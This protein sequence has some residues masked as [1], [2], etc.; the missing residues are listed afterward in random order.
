MANFEKM[1]LKLTPTSEFLTRSPDE[2]VV[3][4]RPTFNHR[5]WRVTE[6][7]STKVD[8]RPGPAWEPRRLVFADAYGPLGQLLDRVR[9]IVFEMNGLSSEQ[10]I[11][12][13]DR[14]LMNTSRMTRESASV[15][16]SLLWAKDRK[17]VKK[18][19]SK[20]APLHLA[21]AE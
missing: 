9:E 21:A 10:E 14:M 16:L 2:R 18:L 13:L 8:S 3:Y 20:Y 7:K 12:R 19:L 11:A 4:V 15:I 17:G 6:K 1:L 5:W